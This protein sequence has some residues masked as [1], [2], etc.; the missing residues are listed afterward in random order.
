M[1]VT[2]NS[3]LDQTKTPGILKPDKMSRSLKATPS[4][5]ALVSIY[6]KKKQYIKDCYKFKIIILKKS[7]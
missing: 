6:S 7:V 2:R 1:Q 4:S 5:L 3:S